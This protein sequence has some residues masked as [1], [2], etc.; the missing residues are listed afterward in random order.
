MPGQLRLCPLRP[1]TPDV[2]VT[3]YSLIWNNGQFPLGVLKY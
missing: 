3:L 2:L 1:Q